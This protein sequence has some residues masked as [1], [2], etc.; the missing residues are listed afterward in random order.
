MGKTIAGAI[1]YEFSLGENISVFG[2]VRKINAGALFARRCYPLSDG[3]GG[4][5]FPFPY[6]LFKV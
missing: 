6:L 4:T 1:A 2:S 3:S 5:V